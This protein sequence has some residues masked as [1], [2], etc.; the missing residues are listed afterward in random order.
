LL[1]EAAEDTGRVP[2]DQRR[3]IEAEHKRRRS[4]EE[5]RSDVRATVHP[6][7]LIEFRLLVQRA[8]WI[9]TTPAGRRGTFVASRALSGSGTWQLACPSCGALPTELLVCRHDHV[10]CAACGKDCTVCG[11]AFCP[12]HGLA[13]CHVDREPA[14]DVHAHT[15][16]ACRRRHCTGH[17]ARCS[18]GDHAACTAC[19]G[20]CGVCGRVV[21]TTHAFQ[22]SV[23]S[24]RG[25]RRLCRDCVVYCEGGTNEPVGRDE[26]V[27]C[28]SCD[29]SVCEAHQAVCA[30]DKQVHCSK[31]LR[32]SDGSR[33]LLCE[34]HRDQCADEPHVIFASDEV[35]H[36]ATCSRKTCDT[37]GGI[38]VVDQQRHC[39]THL[40]RLYDTRDGIACEQHRTVCHVDDRTYSLTGTEPC[41]VCERLA[42]AEHRRRCPWCGRTI[43][44]SDLDTS[45]KRCS[46]CKGLAPFV[47]PPDLLIT[48][49]I[50][51]NGGE[52]PTAKAWRSARDATHTVVELDLGW[53][54]RL[55]FSVRHGDNV[56]QHVMR[57]SI[58][59]GRKQR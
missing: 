24:P 10:A 37:H 23:S 51:A 9:L 56:P 47:D 27:R 59:G 28:A 38:C 1:E 25:A 44:H 7:Q 58:L 36:C 46:T 17:E 55:V 33:R 57:R 52:P 18:E 45:I 2:A 41:P 35:G 11:E 31:H 43:C 19:L 30:V 54:R 6:L 8:E 39:R 49:A 12:Q 3:A 16:P 53:T 21:C 15:C 40:A 20:A 29:K 5:R 22:S 13:E 42:C 4:E 50:E 34:E 32:R 26:A 48:A 14:C